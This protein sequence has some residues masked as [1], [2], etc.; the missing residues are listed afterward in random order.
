MGWM[1]NMGTNNGGNRGEKYEMQVAVDLINNGCRV[2]FPH[3]HSQQYDLIAEEDGELIP[4]QV[5][6]AKTRDDANQYFIKLRNPSK[7]DSDYV[8]LFAAYPEDE[9]HA[10]YVTFSEIMPNGRASV[11]YT[12]PEEMG[13]QVNVDRA[14]LARDY[15]FEAAIAKPRS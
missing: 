8:N 9:A 2:S 14:N 5:K 12:P 6:P 4:I 7:Y 15:T 1:T 3:G 11:T 10:F 13:A